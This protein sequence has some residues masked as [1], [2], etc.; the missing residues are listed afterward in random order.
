MGNAVARYTGF[1]VSSNV[2][3]RPIA[4]IKKNPATMGG[5]LLVVKPLAPGHADAIEFPI[6]HQIFSSQSG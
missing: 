3:F 1:V 2:R 5:A 4:D 6:L